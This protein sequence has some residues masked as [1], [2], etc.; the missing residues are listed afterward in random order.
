[1]AEP[2]SASVN[3]AR[4][5]PASGP[6]DAV[7]HLATGAHDSTATPSA[8]T[9]A[10]AHISP[11]APA[12]SSSSSSSAHSSRIRTRVS[13]SS[14]Q[15]DWDDFDFSDSDDQ[16][17]H[18][19]SDATT[20]GRSRARY[21]SGANAAAA[22]TASASAAAAAAAVAPAQSSST[23]KPL[24]DPSPELVAL[25]ATLPDPHDPV[26]GGVT[27]HARILMLQRKVDRYKARAAAAAAK[28]ARRAAHSQR[29]TQREEV[30]RRKDE[31]KAQYAEHKLGSDGDEDEAFGQPCGLQVASAAAARSVTP[32]SPA[33]SSQ[34]PAAAAAKPAP[35]AEP[36]G[37]ANSATE[38]TSAMTPQPPAKK[39]R[40]Q[41]QRKRP[42]HAHPSPSATAAA[43]AAP[44][45]PPVI[46]R[47][48]VEMPPLYS[49]DDDDDDASS[50]DTEDA[51]ASTFS[52]S[53]SPPLPRWAAE[54]QLLDQ[55]ISLLTQCSN[56]HEP[57][58]AVSANESAVPATPPLSAQSA[59]T[60]GAP[61][62]PLAAATSVI[63]PG[64]AA[65]AA[66][67]SPRGVKRPR[68]PTS[69]AALPVKLQLSSFAVLQT[70][71]DTA[72]QV[73]MRDDET[74]H[75][76]TG[77]VDFS[78]AADAQHTSRSAW[79]WL[80]RVPAR[81]LPASAVP[82]RALTPLP[83]RQS[84]P[85]AA[86]DATIGLYADHDAATLQD[87]PLEAAMDAAIVNS[88]T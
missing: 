39:A 47:V 70:L 88:R 78:Y 23:T 22:A 15:I 84:H 80:Q 31:R 79:G 59:P 64:P 72:E 50:S 36:S 74:A 67:N 37:T 81:A 63:A 87:L 51:D 32:A 68:D 18:D 83:P 6:S 8:T 34:D 48:E 61:L 2:D 3:A 4:L 65:V 40:T 66:G 86:R 24:I 7:A 25:L 20:H 13:R 29:Q 58:L 45:V 73:F 43:A 85:R 56:L 75:A 5:A 21:S 60:R 44:P 38:A 26:S 30:Q 49:S 19:V 82:S 12:P 16:Q 33:A 53:P 55:Q 14:L 28:E 77:D 57:V 69:S 52:P 71:L 42:N 11:A 10:A 17:P 54:W 46:Q 41:T 62:S 1:M 27:K 9:P 35:A 76:L